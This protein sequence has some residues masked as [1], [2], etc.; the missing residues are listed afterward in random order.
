MYITDANTIFYQIFD[1]YISLFNDVSYQNDRFQNTFGTWHGA[2]VIN[3]THQIFIALFFQ[4]R[5]KIELSRAFRSGGRG[6]C[7]GQD[8]VNKSVF[9]AHRSLKD[10]M[11]FYYILF[12][13]LW[14]C[15]KFIT[16]VTVALSTHTGQTAWERGKLTLCHVTEIRHLFL[17]YNSPSK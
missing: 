3:V 16:L 17:Q 4:A 5:R 15:S 7:F 14:W 13:Q 10:Q 6:I 9:L 8:N 12:P 11:A 1:F 2:A